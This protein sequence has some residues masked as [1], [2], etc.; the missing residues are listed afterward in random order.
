[1]DTNLLTDCGADSTPESPPPPR[2][3]GVS[4]ECPVRPA[5]T[6]LDQ[7][8][9]NSLTA[10]TPEQETPETAVEGLW[11][12][13]ACYLWAMLLARLYESTPLV[14]PPCKADMQI[15]AFITDGGSVSR[16]LKHIGE[17]V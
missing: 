2:P 13:P 1:M 7:G 6:A 17:A 15:I 5:M 11:C 16:I 12:S 14:C 3:W 8:T 10:Q 9:E 4:A